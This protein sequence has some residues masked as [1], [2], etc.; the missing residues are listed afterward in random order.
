[1]QVVRTCIID[2]AFKQLDFDCS[3]SLNSTLGSVSILSFAIVYHTLLHIKVLHKAIFR[4]VT[5]G[6]LALHWV[7]YFDMPR[8]GDVPIE[9]IGPRCFLLLERSRGDLFKMLPTTARFALKRLPQVVHLCHHL[10]NLIVD[11]LI[12]DIR[13][14]HHVDRG[15]LPGFK[16]LLK[17]WF[18]LV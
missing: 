18:A 4:F 11:L 8:I 5:H 17:R 10:L 2:C 3:I 13:S 12:F 16:Y 14:I 15:E 6:V 1:M 7:K 9:L